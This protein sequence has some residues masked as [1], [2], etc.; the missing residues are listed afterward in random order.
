MST[1]PRLGLVGE[2]RPALTDL[3]NC[4]RCG[5]CLPACPTYIATG[6]ELE[7]PRGRLYLVR[8]AL[9]G[10]IEARE[11]MLTH[12]DRC[13]QCRACETACPSAVP[14][15]RIVED[16]RT[17]V[18]ARGVRA[19]PPSW[20]LRALV[21]RHVVA[22]PSVRRVAFALGRAYSGSAIQRAL[23][24]LLAA[25]LPRRLRELEALVPDLPDRPFQ[26]REVLAA[27]AGATGRVA[28]LTGCVH[29]DLA[30]QT[31]EATVRVLAHL[32]LRVVAPPD[33]GCC[34]ALHAHA[35]D[36]R[37]ARA[38]ARRNIA[39]FERAGVEAV[40]V[41]AAGCGAAM[42][43]YGRLL[44]N[45]GA[46]AVRAER[47]SATVRDVLEFVASRDFEPGLG[48]LS[49]NLGG[50]D[51]AVQDACHLAHAQ[52]IRDAPRRLLA[53]I[54][55]LRLRELRTPDRCCGSAG[56][57]SIAQPALSGAVLRAKLEDIAETG[58]AMIATSNVGCT[59]QLQAGARRHDSTAD[60]T[61]ADGPAFEV[62]HV[63]EL[64]DASYRA[65]GAYGPEGS[66]DG[67]PSSIRHSEER[68]EPLNS[69][70]SN[71]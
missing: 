30:P 44:R 43:E 66:P 25:V 55:G 20:T 16:A 31:H 36:A 11:P 34:G 45:D 38:L 68:N 70:A 53:A 58:A 10:V 49:G 32:G 60:G 52:G 62:R 61:A 47:F 5:F 6:Q 8:A 7:S 28:L 69:K 35:G 24:G 39:A 65:G 59:L 57:Y 12:L 40:I 26:P 4:I 21:L 2:D 33:Q 18:M 29:G 50:P 71:S 42:K 1:A 56:L 13:L 17:A 63:I 9:D 41:N 48:P 64:L 14:Y 22:R 3:Q 19:R 67:E 46:W 54:P 15:G 23:R 27:P 51:I 37:A